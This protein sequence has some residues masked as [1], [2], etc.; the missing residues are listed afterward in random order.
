MLL[1]TRRCLTRKPVLSFHRLS[2][3]RPQTFTYDFLSGL[4]MKSKTGMGLI[5]LAALNKISLTV[6]VGMRDRESIII[7]M[8][9]KRGNGTVVALR[10]RQPSHLQSVTGVWTYDFL[11]ELPLKSKDGSK[12]T[13]SSLAQLHRISLTNPVPLRNKEAIIIRMLERAPRD[14]RYP[15]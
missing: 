13:L 7:K 5:S 12:M 3:N 1:F 9:G 10:K 6:D 15:E 11:S 14:A 8:L 2:S 4:P